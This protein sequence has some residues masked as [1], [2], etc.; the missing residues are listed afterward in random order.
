MKANTL[1]RVFNQNK[2][3]EKVIITL[4]CMYLAAVALDSLQTLRL[5]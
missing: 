2:L 1:L 4:N 3:K 5:S